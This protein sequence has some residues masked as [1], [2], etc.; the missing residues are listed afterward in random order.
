MRC[1]MLRAFVKGKHTKT[2]VNMVSTFIATR[3]L[4]QRNCRQVYTFVMGALAMQNGLKPADEL[5]FQ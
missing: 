1:I 3:Q 2:V 5:V 4:Y